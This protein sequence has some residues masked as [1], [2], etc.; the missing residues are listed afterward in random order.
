M[1]RNIG[2]IDCTYQ[3][4]CVLKMLVSVGRPQYK[5][6]N[7]SHGREVAIKNAHLFASID[8]FNP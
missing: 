5:I 7:E 8:A 2:S 4:S 6:H 1:L 3:G